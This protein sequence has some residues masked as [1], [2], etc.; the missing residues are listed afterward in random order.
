MAVPLWQASQVIP[1]VE[2]WVLW[3]PGLSGFVAPVAGVASPVG[4]PI[5]AVVGGLP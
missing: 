5:E 4:P 3:A 2:T 1:R